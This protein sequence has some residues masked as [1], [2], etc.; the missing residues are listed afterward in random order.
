VLE[1]L[2]NRLGQEHGQGVPEALCQLREED[3]PGARLRLQEPQS[4]QRQDVPAVRQQ[5]QPVKIMKT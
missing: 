1:Q 5:V 2:P 4:E 3:M